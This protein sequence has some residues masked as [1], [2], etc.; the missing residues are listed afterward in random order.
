MHIY[1][2]VPFCARR[3]SYCDFAIAVRRSVPSERFADAVLREWD[4]RRASAA[5]GGSGAVSTLYFG[6]GTPSHVDPSAIRRVIDHVKASVS[7]TLDAEI[8]LECN[9]DDV[10]AERSSAW[11]A[12]GINRISLG[13]QSFDGRVLEWMH[14]THSVVQIGDAVAVLRQAGLDNISLDL[15]FALPETLNRD[16]PRDLELAFALRPDHLSLYGLTFEPHTPLAK[17]RS[18][19][20]VHEPPDERYATEYLAAAAAFAAAGFDHYE[21]SNAGRPG[22][23]SR[24]NSAY[25]HRTPYLGLGPSAH[26]F[27]GRARSWNRRE[28]EGYRAS[29]EAGEDPR[30]GFEVPSPAQRTLEALYLG[31]RTR[32]GVPWGAVPE[33][34]RRAWLA[35]GWAARSAD[36]LVLTTQGWLRL[37]ALVAS[38]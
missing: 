17:W 1:V 6:G 22:C 3:C 33:R 36:K 37:D 28:W 14:R 38:C 21:V 24:H 16:W 23:W 34:Q 18:R 25:W 11:R 12:A 31:L 8:T 9:P 4:L 5:W 7:L 27:D 20:E 30:D 13:A 26:S 19:G 15:I 32:T 2:H 10:T 35:A 29:V